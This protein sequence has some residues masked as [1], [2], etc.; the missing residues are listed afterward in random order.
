MT[1]KTPEQQIAESSRIVDGHLICELS[2]L[3]VTQ[4]ATPIER[5]Y[6]FLQRKPPIPRTHHLVQECEVPKC[7]THWRCEPMHKTRDAI[8]SEL[9]EDIE[10]QRQ[11]ISDQQRTLA[12]RERQIGNRDALLAWYRV[13]APHLNELADIETDRIIDSKR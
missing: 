7:I 9:T 3:K 4:H 6:W 13:Q 2:A 11:V 8:I 12:L 10:E 5:A 1:K